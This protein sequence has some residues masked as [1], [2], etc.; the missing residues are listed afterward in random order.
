MRST[1]TPRIA[2]WV[3]KDGVK[4]VNDHRSSQSLV[5]A[6]R[7]KV[8]ENPFSIVNKGNK[9]MHIYMS[10]EKRGVD[11]VLKLTE[12][13]V[14]W[15]ALFIYDK[16]TH[17]IRLHSDKSYALSIEDSNKEGKAR[18]TMG[19]DL[20]MR[21][22]AGTMDQQSNIQDG[23]I[24]N[25][26]RRCLTP[27]NYNAKESALLYYWTCQKNP[28]QKW[29]IKFYHLGETKGKIYSDK[30]VEVHANKVHAL[31]Q[32][33]GVNGAKPHSNPFFI[34]LKGSKSKLFM[35]KQIE[36]KDHILKIGKDAKVWRSLFIYDRRTKSI[37]LHAH[38]HLALS[39]EHG[40]GRRNDKRLAM[41]KFTGCKDQIAGFVGEKLKNSKGMCLTPKNYR[42]KQ[43]NLVTFW[44]CN[45]NP[46]QYW[47]H[48]FLVNGGG[49]GDQFSDK[50]VVPSAAENAAPV[51]VAVKA[52]PVKKA[53]SKAS[54]SEKVFKAAVKAAA[55]HKKF[56]L[57]DIKA[58][59]HGQTLAQHFHMH[60]SRQDWIDL[61]QRLANVKEQF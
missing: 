54:R 10:N 8:T 25:L 31:G 28:T 1:N 59:R 15:R 51:K 16:R 61:A 39:N 32:V 20:A 22:W 7:D 56:G 58:A 27:R 5:Q 38:R 46:T 14:N 9:K 49:K 12:D 52:A 45:K 33:T 41:R 2:H 40:K 36:G 57:N 3:T 48:E 13:E 4:K 44:Y 42:D 6:S 21:K 24:K 26:N 34:K 53:A 18:V 19:H 47:K 30:H 35:S 55:A 50:H 23:K 29:S 17:S 43:S 11:R 37:R 60:P